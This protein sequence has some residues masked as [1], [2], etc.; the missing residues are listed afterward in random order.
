VNDY[1]AKSSEKLTKL[2]PLMPV[3]SDM[4]KFPGMKDWI[5][6]R[7]ADDGNLKVKGMIYSLMC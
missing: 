6:K 5:P 7:W 1:S 3:I 4:M 2:P